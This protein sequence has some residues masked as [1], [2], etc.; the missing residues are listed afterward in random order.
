MEKKLLITKFV[1]DRSGLNLRCFVP[2]QLL[3]IVSFLCFDSESLCSPPPFFFFFFFQ[4]PSCQGRAAD[5]HSGIL[6][7]ARLVCETSQNPIVSLAMKRRLVVLDN[8][9]L[10][11]GKGKKHARVKETGEWVTYVLC[12]AFPSTLL[13]PP[14]VSLSGMFSVCSHSIFSSPNPAERNRPPQQIRWQW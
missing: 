2:L 10:P 9:R 5:L 12:V 3:P 4:P 6:C 14:Y 11:I 8:R 7:P 1:V 13:P